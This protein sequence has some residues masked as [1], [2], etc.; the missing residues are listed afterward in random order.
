MS[1]G[2]CSKPIEKYKVTHLYHSHAYVVLTL[3]AFEIDFS[4]LYRNRYLKKRNIKK[5]VLLIK[6]LSPYTSAIG[7]NLYALHL[8]FNFTGLYMQRDFVFESFFKT[9]FSKEHSKVIVVSSGIT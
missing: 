2:I 6:F 4:C 1:S 5:E 9:D 7:D 3:I 8:T